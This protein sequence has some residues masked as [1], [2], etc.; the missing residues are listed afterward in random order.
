M[1]T[2]SVRLC[3]DFPRT[4]DVVLSRPHTPFG[5]SSAA[6]HLGEDRPGWF[7]Q[8]CLMARSYPGPA[9]AHTTLQPTDLVG[10]SPSAPT[11]HVG[12]SGGT[13]SGLPL[14]AQH[15]YIAGP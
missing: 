9:L 8:Q 11:S 12:S 3:P 6:R 5:S 15:P 13:P 7:K 10:W 4:G 1:G 14:V 2:R